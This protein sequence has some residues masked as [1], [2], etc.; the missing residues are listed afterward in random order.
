MGSCGDSVKH[1]S[2]RL[3]SLGVEELEVVGV[4]LPRRS[5]HSL[6]VV[7]APCSLNYPTIRCSGS[8]GC[9]GGHC[10]PELCGSKDSALLVVGTLCLIDDG[11]LHALVYVVCALPVVQPPPAGGPSNGDCVGGPV[12]PRHLLP[13]YL[14]RR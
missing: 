7:A 14:Q 2:P 11:S 12:R 6:L 1:V 5:R 13:C 8:C 4:A 9:F 3:T 10:G